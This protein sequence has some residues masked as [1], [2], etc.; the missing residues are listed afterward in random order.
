M[1]FSLSSIISSII[2]F[3]SS[4]MA[5]Y[6]LVSL[7]FL[8]SAFPVSVTIDSSDLVAF[9]PVFVSLLRLLS[10]FFVLSSVV[11]PVSRGLVADFSLVA[12]ICRIF[13]SVCCLTVGPAQGTV[14]G[15]T[16]FLE[17]T[18]P[19]SVVYR[20]WHPEG[21]LVARGREVTTLLA[22]TWSS[23]LHQLTGPGWTLKGMEVAAIQYF[24]LATFIPSA[25][26]R[27]CRA[28]SAL[29]WKFAAAIQQRLPHHPARQ[30][31]RAQVAQRSPARE[32]P[33]FLQIANAWVQSRDFVG[34]AITFVV[35]APLAALLLVNILSFYLG[36][37]ALA[38][39]RASQRVADGRWTKLR[40]MLVQPRQ[41]VG[42]FEIY[43]GFPEWKSPVATRPVYTLPRPDYTIE[44]WEALLEEARCR[45]PWR[46][47]TLETPWYL[48]QY[49]A[50]PDYRVRLLPSPRRASGPR[51]P[52]QDPMALTSP[53][54][55]IVDTGIFG[56]PTSPIPPPQAQQHQVWLLPP[57]GQAVVEAPKVPLFVP[58]SS[59]SFAFAFPP[60]A[61]AAAT[62]T[63]T[64]LP[65]PAP[66]S[67]STA[68]I[69]EEVFREG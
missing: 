41:P 1:A 2:S 11:I 65:F 23:S 25:N 27:F 69:A 22:T 19:R 24:I 54:R 53:R 45:F 34:S 66:T 63:V 60:P 46:L 50:A 12:V 5:L 49:Y 55:R 59:A 64:T 61:T 48:R 18:H 31:P 13:L 28:F 47:A 26:V 38:L 52:F 17:P 15:A 56:A 44:S 51:H 9:I 32:G 4:P 57:M 20:N 14:A 6:P 68:H 37:V 58:P 33:G 8:L 36:E 16:Y 10:A 21:S 30:E 35:V 40:Q 42:G 29:A 3:V 62:T 43:G 7:T 39:K 67:S